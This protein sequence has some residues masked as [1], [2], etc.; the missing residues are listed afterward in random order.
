M[1]NKSQKEIQNI[2]VSEP[3][4]QSEEKIMDEQTK[5]T[6]MK[7]PV[8]IKFIK[9]REYSP[10]SLSG[11]SIYSASEYD[12]D[13]KIILEKIRSNTLTT[14][15]SRALGS[16]LGNIV[17][18]ALGAPFEFS[19]VQYPLPTEYELKG[20]DIKNEELTK[21]WKDVGY[22]RFRLQPGQWTDGNISISFNSSFIIFTFNKDASMALCLADSLILNEKLSIQDLRYRFLLWWFLGWNNA[23]GYDD[24]R[25]NKHSVGL[26]GN[27]HASFAEFIKNENESFTQAGD[28]E[29]SGNGS[30]MR[31]SPIPLFAHYDLNY[32]TQL[33]YE[34]SR[35][36]HQG[37]EAAE[38]C[39]LLTFI[40]VNAF[41][42]GDG[43]KNVLNHLS[44]FKSKL[45]SVNCLAQSKNEESHEE[46]KHLKLEDRKWNWKDKTY[47]YCESRAVK[48]PGYIG[49]YV[50]DALAMALHCVWTTN[51]FEEALLKTASTFNITLYIFTIFN[52]FLS[53]FLN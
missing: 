47:R 27:I 26:G 5:Q 38:C 8:A 20:M 30:I 34:Q 11:Y 48:K 10:S 42:K 9:K 24:E 3:N 22:N 18:D 23:F 37:E 43:T 16:F 51:S 49:S 35:S 4:I 19:A 41:H 32:A 2:L 13:R 44:E 17:G 33:A 12:E 7:F 21:V 36:T 46:N 15:E 1:G 14:L 6:M 28:K 50:M 45:Y 31:N 53:F 25:S 29:T 39:R 52:K 40:V